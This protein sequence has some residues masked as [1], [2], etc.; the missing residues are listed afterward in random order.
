MRR[1]R[2]FKC[3]KRYKEFGGGGEGRGIEEKQSGEEERVDK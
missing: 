2:N 3:G 1:K